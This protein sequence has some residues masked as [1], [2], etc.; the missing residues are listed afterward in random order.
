MKTSKYPRDLAKIETTSRR[1]YDVDKIKISDPHDMCLLNKKGT[2]TVANAHPFIF[3]ALARLCTEYA[4]A[5]YK[6]AMGNIHDVIDRQDNPTETHYRAI[7]KLAT[8]KE[9]ALNGHDEYWDTLHQQICH[10]SSHPEKK[11][12]PFTKDYTILTE[13]VKIDLVNEAG[14]KL[15]VN[16]K[17]Q[18]A[19]LKNR[20]HPS[21]GKIALVM[22]E[23]YK[24]LFSCLLNKNKQKELGYNYIQIPRGLQAE[25]KATIEKLVTIGFFNGTDLDAEKVPLYA[26]DARAIFLYMAQHDNRMGEHITIDALDFAMSCFPGDVK[27]MEKVQCNADGTTKTETT[28]YMSKADGFK[29][30]SKIKKTIITFK[31]MGRIGKMDGGQ[32]I[33]IE[34]D[35]NTVQYNHE[36]Q[37]YRIKV[38]RPKNTSAPAYNPADILP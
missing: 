17:T 13:P 34:L 36:A 33:P 22:I 21:M 27:L 11:V 2:F 26:T 8:F 9:F 15:S 25:L 3:D 38:L 18:L 16:E 14:E 28:K 31:Q 4:D 30:R 35:E 1:Q 24:P 23:F 32:F 29:I 37:K 12:M 6:D 20:K 7:L 10:L 19:N 5:K